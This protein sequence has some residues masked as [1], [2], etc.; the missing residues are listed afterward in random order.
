MKFKIG[1]IYFGFKLENEVKIDEI[2]SIGR[3]FTHIK[4]GA[5]LVSLE[6][7]DDNKT[8]SIT[9]K[10]LPQNSKGIPHILEHSVLCGSRKFPVKEPFVEILKGSLNTYLNAATYPDK[11]MFP[12][13]SRN[14]KDFRNLMNVYLDAVFYPAIYEKPEIFMQ[15]GW[16]YDIDNINGEID[17]KGIVYNEMKGAYS[18]PVAILLRTVDETLFKDNIYRFDSGG[19]PE[20]IVKLSSNE[21]IKFHEEYY[22]PSNSIIYLYGDIKLDEELKFINDEYLDKFEKKAIKND[23]VLQK[24]FEEMTEKEVEYSISNSES[25]DDKTFF[26]LSFC[27]GS[28]LD[29]ELYFAFDILESILLGLSSSPL[30]RALVEANIGKDVFGVFDNSI[31]QPTF[32]I[33]LKDSNLKDKNKFKDIVFSVL[34]ELCKNGID[35][36]VIEAVINAREFEIKEADYESYPRGLEYNEKILDRM[37]YGGEPFENLRYEKKLKKMK[38]AMNSNYFEKI[39]KKYFLNNKHSA[40]ITVKPKK[41]LEYETNKAVLKDLKIFRDN[42]NKE[43][44]EEIFEQNRKLKLRYE[45][46][47]KKEDLDK[48]P[49]LSIK[50]INPKADYFESEKINQNGVDILYTPLNTNGINYMNLYF[51]SSVVPVDMIPYLSLF[52]ILIGRMNTKKYDFKDLSNQVN[53]NVG[54]MDFSLEPYSDINEVDKYVPE[55]VIRTKVLKEKTF[56]LLELLEEV[57]NK[58]IYDDYKR[59]KELIEELKSRLE[60]SMQ[61][62]SHRVAAVR[63]GSYYSQ[64]YKYV[65]II[66][67]IEFYKFLCNLERSFDEK[68]ESIS[69]KLKA[70]A[71]LVFNSNNMLVGYAGDRDALN[72]FLKLFNEFR[73]RLK[74]E[75]I[76]KYNYDFK[77]EKLNEGLIISSKIQ[78]VVKGYNFKKLNFQNSGVLSVVKSIAN[79]DYLWSK[80]RVQGGAYGAFASFSGNGNMNLCSYRDPG[81]AETIEIYDDFADYIKNFNADYRE[82]T[83]YILGTISGIDAPLSNASK[84]ERTVLHYITNIDMDYIQRIRDEIINADIYSIRKCSKLIGDCMKENYICVIGNEQ[85]INENADKFK[86]VINIFAES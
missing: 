44:L 31:L 4:S 68:K 49:M 15:E 42:L 76:N 56:K 78:C 46:Q 13:A 43:Q 8:F 1:D 63:I 66:S 38:T 18:S 47:D 37:L 28:I 24:A 71:K 60:M 77:L 61:S 10:T 65:D 6:N 67:G 57:I 79:Y 53:M 21:F 83:K 64:M 22:H 34:E 54:G 50:D 36:K 70:C 74:N 20:E 11:T 5:K 40:L 27:T 41:N 55:F 80:V 12:V 32:S 82:I 35:R 51:D 3:V 75:P 9:F 59:L 19:K 14:Y 17:Y 58:T 39:I 29:E 33:I 16:H 52:S 7:D 69:E 48:I 23:I 30:K 25:E 45:T 81:L 73:G 85:K 62:R 2:K 84:C 26:S 72:E 86:R